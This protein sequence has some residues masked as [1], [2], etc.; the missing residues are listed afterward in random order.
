[1]DF[2][3]KA[4]LLGHDLDALKNGE[5]VQSQAVIQN[6]AD[7][8]A[9][10]ASDLTDK[11]RSDFDAQAANSAARAAPGHLHAVT[12]SVF[13]SREL[14]AEEEAWSELMFP[15]AIT[16]TSGATVTISD[17]LVQGPG[18]PPWL[19]NAQELV[20]DGG[21]VTAI[22][23]AL[24]ITADSVAVV[25]PSSKPYTVGILGNK[26]ATGEPGTSGEPYNAPAK[27]GSDVSAPS[28]GI[29][30]GASRGGTGQNGLPG[31]PGQPGQRGQDGQPNMPAT[32]LIKAVSPKNNGTFAIFT[33]SGPGGDGGTGGDGGPGQN[34][35]RGGNG[36]DSGCEGTDGGD[37]GTGG[38]GGD[39]NVG[40][41]GG[42]GVPGNTIHL[43]FPSTPPGVLATLSASAP[44]GKGGSGG[45][46][47]AA[48][49]PGDGGSGG[50]HSTNGQRGTGTTNGAAGQ[51]GSDGTQ[52]G[53]PGNFSR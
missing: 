25:Q 15:I 24:T 53:A 31:N 6:L 19:I 33:Q 12:Q 17:D 23:T 8:K 50:K 21:S 48:G 37:G 28:P 10:F 14:T 4:E 35:G 41:P 44:Y 49:Q 29:C 36:C 20:F 51:K 13:G 3:K 9:L 30:T 46:G 32:I 22:T 26:G 7:F 52:S 2:R 42:N 11:H 34:G 40:G 1:M 5:T 18:A 43:S 27:A 45:K 38:K 39:G 47:G 16:A